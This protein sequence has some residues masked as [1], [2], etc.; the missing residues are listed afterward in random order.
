MKNERRKRNRLKISLIVVT[1]I[2]M[3]MLLTACGEA[4]N[5]NTVRYNLKVIDATSDFYVND[6]AGVFT[7]DQKAK[8]MDNAVT[9]AEET[10]GIQVVITTVETLKD[11]VIEDGETT[12]SY[13][14]AEVG[15][16]MFAQ[17]GIGKDD[18]GI[19]IL[20]SPGDRE[21]RIDT[22]YQM[23][24]YITDAT[25]GKILDDY[26]MKYFAEDKFAEGLIAVQEGTITEIKERVPSNWQE[27][28]VGAEPQETEKT[29]EETNSVVTDIPNEPQKDSNGNGL[30]Y[31]FFGTIFAAL[32]GIGAAIVQLF[33]GKSKEKE[34]E[35]KRK[36]DLARQ[37]SEFDLRLKAQES[38][39]VSDMKVATSAFNREKRGLENTISGLK[40]QLATANNQNIELSAELE[41]L[42]DKFERAQK[43]HPE[44]D[45]ETEVH[46]MIEAE[47]KTEAEAFDEQMATILSTAVDKDNVEIFAS[48]L[49]KFD[50]LSDDVAK[51]VTTK[52]EEVDQMYKTSCQLRQ[53][54]ERQ[55]QER[56]DRAA[57]QNVYDEI[58]NI[59]NPQMRGN[60]G[61]FNALNTALGMYLTL[62]AAQKA[63]FPDKSLISCLQS[64]FDEAEEDKNNYT[65]AKEA[66]SEVESII[67]RCYTPDEDDRDDLERAM[68]IYRRLSSAEQA[69]FS[70]ELLRK[71]KRKMQEA[72][73]DHEEQE[74]RRRAARQSSMSSSSIHRTGGFS[75]G[76]SHSGFGGRPSGGGAG[77]KF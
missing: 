75:S 49:S 15:Y 24:V 45:F 48:A 22:G 13:T 11:A 39:H 12:G 62:S 32:A 20:F 25:S 57:A 50:D 56:K 17:Y 30:L 53:E 28:L 63:F 73:D 44:F 70:D 34:Q 9:F 6:F 33:K 8:L 3:C 38:K 29:E 40:S 77:R 37:K 64:T 61:N 5:A 4:P 43:L 74:R 23:Q 51:Y 76:S 42:Q 14:F 21:V 52:R 2:V 67:S 1:A 47:F 36:E 58:T 72:E 10:G 31:G 55:E 59:F 46:E 68:R 7:E 18:M 41:E 71:L 65:A 69:Y 27:S 35:A 26:G 54:F 19:L 66:E 60:R 16:S